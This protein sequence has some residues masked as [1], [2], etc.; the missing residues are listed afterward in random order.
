M[1][2]FLKYRLLKPFFMTFQ[3]ASYEPDFQFMPLGH[4]QYYYMEFEKFKTP[5]SRG[6]RIAGHWQISEA[7]GFWPA[8]FMVFSHSTVSSWSLMH[9]PTC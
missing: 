7:K 3:A 1:R 6:P 4:W 5:D 8:T 9:L 2:A